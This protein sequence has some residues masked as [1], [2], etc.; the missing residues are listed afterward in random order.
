MNLVIEYKTKSDLYNFDQ[1]FSKRR[2]NMGKEDHSWKLALEAENRRLTQLLKE[3]RQ[4]LYDEEIV[5]Q[6][7]TR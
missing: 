6:L 3:E 7:A 1:E 2:E 5:R 4:A